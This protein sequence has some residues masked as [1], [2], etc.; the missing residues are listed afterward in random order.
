M[1]VRLAAVLLA[2]GLSS[3]CAYRVTMSST[4]AAA[5]VQLPDGGRTVTPD[6]VVLRWRPFQ[7]QVVQVSAPGYRT[8]AIDLRDREIRWSRY[9]TDTLFRPAT[10]VGAP[11]G[12]VRFV[13]VPEH[14][15]VG[16]WGEDDVP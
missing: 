15:P 3:G 14:G 6:E 12:D 7:S 8:V 16:T 10:L 9:V 13:L 2:G 11:R 4:P 5:T 1:R